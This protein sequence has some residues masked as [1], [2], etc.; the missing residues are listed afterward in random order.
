MSGEILAERFAMLCDRANVRSQSLSAVRRTMRKRHFRPPEA[1]P[2][3]DGWV[4]TR[5]IDRYLVLRRSARHAVDRLS[6]K[7]AE[8]VPECQIRH[9]YCHQGETLAAV[10]KR[11]SVHLVPQSREVSGIRSDQQIRYGLFHYG[12]DGY[13][14]A[15]RRHAD[16]SIFRFDF[17]Q[18]SARSLVSGPGSEIHVVWIDR[19]WVRLRIIDH[20]MA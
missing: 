14:A 11:R 15:A 16:S 3:E 12:A 7:L 13:P 1:S 19:E 4:G 17:D 9:A 20:P 8:Q 2:F 10:G 18:Y 5:T 6:S